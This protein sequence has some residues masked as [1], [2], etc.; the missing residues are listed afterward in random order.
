MSAAPQLTLWEQRGR[1]SVA[2]RYYRW[3]QQHPDV[4]AEIERRVL[5][6]SA[7]GDQRIEVNEIWASVRA[8]WKVKLDNSHRSL[9]ARELIQRHPHLTTKIEI[10]KR[11]S[12]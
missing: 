9:A 2:D 12:A 4:F 6:C 11:R 7:R 8:D 1:G 3:R 5:A 10:R